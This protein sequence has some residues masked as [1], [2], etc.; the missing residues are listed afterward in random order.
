MSDGEDKH[1]A[2]KNE[3]WTNISD[4]CTFIPTL[5]DTDIH[6]MYRITGICK[7]TSWLFS[8]VIQVWELLS[9]LPRRALYSNK[10]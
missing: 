8:F 2:K 3:G 9:Y 10:R 5:T 1:G 4:I 6:C 7:F